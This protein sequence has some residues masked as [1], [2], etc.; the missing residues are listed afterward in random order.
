MTKASVSEGRYVIATSDDNV[1]CLSTHRLPFEPKGWLRSMR[2]DLA[3]ALRALPRPSSHLYARYSSRVTGLAD[4]EN[5]LFYNVGA[6]A[7][8]GLATSPVTF[9]RSFSKMSDLPHEALYSTLPDWISYWMPEV[10]IADWEMPLSTTRWGTPELKVEHLWLQMKRA[11]VL[12]AGAIPAGGYG[13]RITLN[14]PA[15]RSLAL[16]P[17]VKRLFDGVISGLH[18]YVG[19]RLV[20][21]SSRLSSRLALEPE[22]ASNLLTDERLAPLGKREV[23]WP[24]G[25]WVQWNPADGQCMQ[26]ILEREFTSSVW[27]LRAK[28]YTLSAREGDK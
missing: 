18:S 27:Q 24:F 23:V 28:L 14:G 12:G 4:A 7:F 8:T 22:E 19:A 17:S 9:G 10:I 13:L 6:S 5:V 3:E 20:D 11:R 16:M 15:G 26:G 21:V 1:T 25:T 2:S